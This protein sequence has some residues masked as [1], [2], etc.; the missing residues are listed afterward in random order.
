MARYM[1]WWTQPEMATPQGITEAARAAGVLVETGDYKVGTL[2]FGDG[3]PLADILV[4]GTVVAVADANWL[5][6]PASSC[7]EGWRAQEVNRRSGAT[8][9]VSSSLPRQLGTAFDRATSIV[10]ALTTKASD[11][12]DV[13]SG[14]RAA[15]IDVNRVSLAG[16]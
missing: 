15:A 6:Y 5:V 9:I 12:I 2:D 1:S 4:E 13:H 8:E 10:G 3:G 7:E 14:S 11:S 16:F